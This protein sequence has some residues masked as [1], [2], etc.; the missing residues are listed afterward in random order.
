M[1]RY[2][3][4]CTNQVPSNHPPQQ[5][6]I[7]QVGIGVTADTYRQLL[8]IDEVI[9]AMGRGEEFYTKGE[10]SGREASVHKFWCTPCSRY[11]I[12]SGA[13]AVTDN[14]LDSLTYC[15]A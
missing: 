8:T 6:H 4:T 12:R 10:T 2:R 3:I 7:V 9:A 11:Y 5:A 1:A 15:N 14:N 13:D